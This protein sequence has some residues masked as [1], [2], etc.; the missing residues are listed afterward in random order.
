MRCV[1]DDL[2]AQTITLHYL[3]DGSIS[4]RFLY[5]KQEF[6]V[7]II[8][9]LKGLKN[10]TD[11]EIYEQ[12]VRGNFTQKQIS[13]RVEAILAQGKNQNIYDSN[14]SKALI[15]S[16]FRVVLA[17]VT[18]EMSDIEV[19]DLFLSKYIC[20]HTS[21][22]ESKFNTLLLM[23]NKLYAAVS[24][25]TEFDNLDSVAHHDVLLGGHLY[26]QILAENLFD[27]LH[28]NLRARITREIKRDSF[29]AQKFRDINTT[30]RMI[31]SSAAIGKRIE[32]FLATGNLIS[33][34]N[35]DLMQTSGF[36]IIADKLN[37]I[38]YLSHFRSIHRG[39]YFAEQKTTSVRKLLPESW[40][41]LCPVHTPDGAPC[42]LLNHISMSCVPIGSEESDIDINTLQ[43]A[44]S[45]LGM[46]SLTS[47]LCLNYNCSYY[48]V[49]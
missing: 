46:N 33:R 37:N 24:D 40:G 18:D 4:L 49:M 47:D 21:S 26:M 41:F 20:I 7:P 25:E 17:G 45:E 30:T 12:I 11:R 6:L 43:T 15:G 23:I 48:P 36:S 32:N 38:R 35:L 14:Q 34:T 19:G 16:R 1:R 31:E 44:L 10:C 9:L 39:Q 3:S 5:Q 22:Y 42:G 29:D 27:A 28:I 8:I 2:T 13:D